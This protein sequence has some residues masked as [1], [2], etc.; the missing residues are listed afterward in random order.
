VQTLIK[1]EKD[2]GRDVPERFT[3]FHA[4]NAGGDP[5]YGDT[6]TTPYGEKL[7]MV[8]AKDITR[9]LAGISLMDDSD[10]FHAAVAYLK[11]VYRDTW[12]AL[13]WH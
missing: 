5:C 8:R 3:T 7:R 1:V 6:Q 2:E 13:Y 10:R 4:R 12:V 11:T 9:A